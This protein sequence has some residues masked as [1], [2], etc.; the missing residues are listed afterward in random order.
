MIAGVI[1]ALTLWPFGSHHAKPAA[2][3]PAPIP[4]AV[5]PSPSEMAVLAHSAVSF[6]RLEDNAVS[7]PGLTSDVK[8]CYTALGL[9]P[10]IGRAA[11]C[12][13]LDTAAGRIAGAGGETFTPDYFKEA[14]RAERELKLEQKLT[15]PD[16]RRDFVREMDEAELAAENAAP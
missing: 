6:A 3:P 8:T 9:S 10:T 4:P 5:L 11:Y 7:M 13:M 16:Q 14:V 1:L 12:I 2:A 15:P